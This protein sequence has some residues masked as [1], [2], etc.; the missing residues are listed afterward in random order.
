MGR[1]RLIRKKG[2]MKIQEMAFVLIAIFIF[3]S[4]VGLIYF[5][6]RLAGLREDVTLQREESAKETIRKIA[7]I[8]EFS[9]AECSQCI[10]A[11]KILALKSMNIYKKFWDLDY[12]MV[13]RVYP[14]S[15]S[16]AECTKINYPEC[17]TITLINA[18]KEIG[19]PISSYV[20]LC[21]FDNNEQNIKCELG[22]IYASIRAVK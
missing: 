16:D 14:N 22:R 13:E 3:F 5:S 9:W 10:D 17:R 19:I 7:E 20:A 21:R 2:Q 18:T 6:I 4:L 11:D 12:L 8:P 15:G 1:L